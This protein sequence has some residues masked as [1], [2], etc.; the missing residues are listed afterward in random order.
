MIADSR[1][2]GPATC[3]PDPGPAGRSRCGNTSSG[4]A[5]R[6]RRRRFPCCGSA[7]SRRPRAACASTGIKPAGSRGCAPV[8]RGSRWRRCAPSPPCFLMPPSSLMFLIFTTRRGVTRYF[9]H[10]AEQIRAAG[11]HIH[12]APACCAEHPDR[13][14]DGSR[15]GIFEVLHYAF[16]LSSAASTR[17]AVSGT[18]GTLTPMAFA[19]ALPMAATTPIVGGSPSPI[20]PRLSCSG[21]N[22]HVHH[23]LA[24]IADAGQLVELHIGV[25][26][27]A[28]SARS[29]TRSSIS[30]AQMPM[31]TAPWIW[32]SASLGLITRPHILHGDEL[33]HLDDAGLRIHRDFGHL[34]AAHAAGHQ[35]AGVARVVLAH[36]RDFV[37]AQL[38][39][40]L[41]PG[42]ALGGIAFHLDAADPPRELI[43]RGVQGRRHRFEQLIPARSRWISGW[44]AKRRR[45][46]WNRPKPPIRAGSCFAD[47]AA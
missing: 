44:T 26:H 41:L 14:L 8:R 25:Q 39:A 18:C 10:Q 3:R 13:L 1:H 19:T 2:R 43:G 47:L 46:W 45:R 21:R 36:L 9:L 15:V 29:I 28:A 16:L 27:A 33:V 34:H 22:V 40:G 7:G 5:G 20:T 11:Q 30:A 23:D 42:Q 24:N 6:G 31:I 12:F 32:L 38:G 37:D 4:D 35:S 17:S